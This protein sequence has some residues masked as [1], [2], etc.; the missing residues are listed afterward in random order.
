MKRRGIK[1]NKKQKELLDMYFLTTHKL[2]ITPKTLNTL[3]KLSSKKFCDSLE[4]TAN[5]YLSDKYF[6]H[7]A[8]ENSPW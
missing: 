5:R 7:K 2:F 1:L 6:E 3:E 4:S 8:R